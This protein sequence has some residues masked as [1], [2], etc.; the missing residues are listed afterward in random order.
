MACSATAPGSPELSGV[1]GPSGPDPP[2]TVS[3][4]SASWA[5]AAAV[6]ATTTA[7]S[8]A[9]SLRITL[10][11]S[12]VR[13]A[14]RRR[15]RG[16]HG[17]APPDAGVSTRLGARGRRRLGTLGAVDDATTTGEAV[18]E[19]APLPPGYPAEWDADVVLAD[20]STVRIRPILPD[21]GPRLV[22]FHGRQ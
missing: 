6:T 9:L 8:S 5:Q 22:D 10:G 19:E 4:P 15:R 1:G 2:S 20:G 16:P 14:A 7:A 3:S 17:S 21:D 12:F 18:G 13:R 11:G